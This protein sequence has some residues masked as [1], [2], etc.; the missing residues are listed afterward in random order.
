MSACAPGDIALMC[1]MSE[2][3]MLYPARQLAISMKLSGAMV[4][5][6]ASAYEEITGERIEILGRDGRHFTES[7]RAVMLK[8]KGLID[9]NPGMSV[10]AAIRAALGRSEV[11][12]KSQGGVLDAETLAALA[13][14]FRGDLGAIREGL[15]AIRE[16]LAELPLLRVE[17][18]ALRGELRHQGRPPSIPSD[19]SMRPMSFDGPVEETTPEAPRETRADLR[20]ASGGM[21]VRLA[22]RLE[23]LL[24]FRS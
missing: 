17:V 6:Y 5:K 16:G 7:Q 14:P 12:V 15:S 18:K 9:A 4:R 10:D 2:S 22:R 11:A 23:R 8:A 13:E 19:S 21:L 24:K 1:G 3:A 20:D